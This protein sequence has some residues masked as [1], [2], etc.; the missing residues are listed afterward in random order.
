[1]HSAHNES[2]QETIV[3][4]LLE[5]WGTS[6]KI[7]LSLHSLHSLHGLQSAVCMVCV[8]TWPV[9]LYDD[10]NCKSLNK[11]AEKQLQIKTYICNK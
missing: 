2:K 11:Q 10:Q 6:K 9:S 7:A 5:N 1:M 3:K 8:S 4:I